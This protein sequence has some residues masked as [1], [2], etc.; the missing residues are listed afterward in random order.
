[1]TPDRPPRVYAEWLPL[2]DRFAA[3]EDEVLPV[4]QAGSLEWTNVVAERFTKR[5]ANALATRLQRI[6]TNLQRALDRA[7]GDPF[8]VSHALLGA[9]R[10]LVPLRTVATFSCA[11]EVVRVMLSGEVTR[12]ATRTQVALEA[13]AV[14]QR[15]AGGPLL[16]ALRDNPLTAPI[17]SIMVGADDLSGGLPSRRGRRVLE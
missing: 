12:F 7:A 17:E 9:R 2:V 13:S 14:R 3:G 6:A 11:P 10:A 8:D 15:L 1:M 5:L 16:K 4:M